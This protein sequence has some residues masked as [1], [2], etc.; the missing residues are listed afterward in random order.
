MSSN[1]EFE[2]GGNDSAATMS[3]V[4]LRRF[5]IS[6]SDAPHLASRQIFRYELGCGTTFL[7]PLAS[8][9]RDRLVQPTRARSQD[10]AS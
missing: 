8:S 10:G 9:H 7:E 4:P 6:E 2:S 1:E 5:E 3:R